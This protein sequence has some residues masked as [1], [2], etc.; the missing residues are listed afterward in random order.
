MTACREGGA[1]AAATLPELCETPGPTASARGF[2]S[3][4]QFPYI[5]VHMHA[6]YAYTPLLLTETYRLSTQIPETEEFKG[7]QRFSF[8]LLRP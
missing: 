7:A 6:Q 3:Q 4:M 1:P 2:G 8:L 5:Y